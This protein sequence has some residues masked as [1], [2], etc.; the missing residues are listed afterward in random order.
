MQVRHDDSRWH[1]R[2]P[3]LMWTACGLP[4]YRL[5]QSLRHDSHEGPLCMSCF[6]KFEHSLS[7][8]LERADRMKNG[9][10]K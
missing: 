10:D 6:T 2:T 9:A 5:G 1:R 4:L 7:A 8:E 3:D